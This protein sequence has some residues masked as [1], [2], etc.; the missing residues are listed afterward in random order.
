MYMCSSQRTVSQKQGEFCQLCGFL[1]PRVLNR[2]RDLPVLAQALSETQ[3]R[4]VR[5]PDPETSDILESLHLACVLVVCW[6]LTD[7]EESP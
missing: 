3:R 7:G 5:R 2:Q 1:H 4:R 6:N